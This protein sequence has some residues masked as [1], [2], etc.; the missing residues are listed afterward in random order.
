MQRSPTCVQLSRSTVPNPDQF[1]K[2]ASRATLLV[3]ALI[4]LSVFTLALILPADLSALLDLQ[5]TSSL[6][7]ILSGSSL[8]FAGLFLHCAFV[9]KKPVAW[10]CLLGKGV[11]STSLLVAIFAGDLPAS[12]L[13]LIV[14]L[15]FVWLLPLG[16]I[17]FHHHR[18]FPK[19]AGLAPTLCALCHIPGL[20]ALLV[21]LSGGSEME[22]NVVTRAQYISHHSVSWSC[23]W[24]I[25]M[26]SAQTL[27]G[28]YAWW[29]SRLKNQRLALIGV[30]VAGIG[31]ISDL[32]G[33]SIYTGSLP[34][35]ARLLANNPENPSLQENFES[36]QN[37]A[38]NL[39][40]IWANGFYTLGGMILTLAT[41]NLTRFLRVVTWMIWGAGIV[42]SFSAVVG[43]VPGIVLGSAI[44]FPLLIPWCW[45]MGIK[46]K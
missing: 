26:I 4:H 38:T 5:E 46:L 32:T 13:S 34:G 3:G 22:P 21:M 15:D 17:V 20:I 40:A 37:L 44:L 29:G 18:S 36:I 45:W 39:T 14:L 12:T 25:W 28:F 16:W 8:L 35:A 10:A 41:S 27:L 24:I 19:L 6:L 11:Q 43:W 1:G 42:M 30:L 33:E 7:I 2:N 9:H 23:G 31:M